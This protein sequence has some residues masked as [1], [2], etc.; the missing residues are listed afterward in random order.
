MSGP[1][2]RILPP[3]DDFDAEEAARLGPAELLRRGAALFDAGA[4]HD[5]HEEWEKVWLAGGAGDDDFWKG[6]IQAAICLHHFRRGELEGARKLYR[7]HRAYLAAFLPT[8]RGLDVERLLAE[9]QACL[10]PVLRAAADEAVPFELSAAPRL[11][12]GD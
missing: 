4:Y 7:G 3:E 11:G 10:R 9:M 12:L 8:H 6:L 1:I 2:E 5:A